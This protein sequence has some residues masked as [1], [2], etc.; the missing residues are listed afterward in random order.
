MECLYRENWTSRNGLG[1]L[2]ITPTRELALQI[3]EVIEPL[4]KTQQL[5]SA[6]VVGGKDLQKEWY[7]I[8]SFNI[9]VAT[10]GR[11]FQLMTECPN[12]Q[13]D[14]LRILALDEA[15]TCLSMG[16]AKEMNTILLQLPKP[17]Q[18]LLFS[19][20]QTRDVLSLAKAGCTNPVV[21][22]IHENSATSTPLTLTQCYTI[23]EAHDKFNF[24]YSFLKN[25]KKQKILVFLST[26]KQVN[27]FGI[28]LTLL[29]LPMKILTYH[30]DMKQPRRAVVYD[31]FKNEKK[32]V[33]LATD[34][35]ARG[36]GKCLV[37]L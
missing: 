27:F 1:A 13:W 9:V 21:C 32:I 2:I 34:V 26:C 35:A 17:R 3:H 28:A 8:N 7:Y 14:S 29:K 6:L 11:L 25:F 36:L 37:Y 31:T 15:D 23:C 10:P 30:G 18:T 4:A 24:I 19:A 16:F 20:T 12:F 33:M 5:M 22:S